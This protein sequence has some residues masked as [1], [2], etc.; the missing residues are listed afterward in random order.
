MNEIAPGLF[1]WTTFHDGIG[2]EVSSYYVEPS[3][4]V[5]DPMTP[6]DGLDWFAGRNVHLTFIDAPGVSA[7]TLQQA[8]SGFPG[9]K[10]FTKSAYVDKQTNSVN[11]LLGIFYA[12]LALA[13]IVSLLGL[14]NTLVLATFERTVDVL[15]IDMCFLE[16]TPS[17]WAHAAGEAEPADR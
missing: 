5:L 2:H 1:H 13:V 10:V 8:V 7:A 14:A 11:Q 3:A 15:R 17:P 6:Q 4:T 9:A 12:L 16:I